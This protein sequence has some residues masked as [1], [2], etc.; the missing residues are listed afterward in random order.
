MKRARLGW[1]ALSVLLLLM[2]PAAR[3]GAQAARRVAVV[4]GANDA[5]PGRKP[6]RFSHQDAQAFARVLQDVAGFAA[7][8]VLVM[9]DPEPQALLEALD[10]KLA[11]LGASA[12]ETLVLFYYSGHADSAALFPHGRALALS[13]LR[14]RLGDARAGVRVGI[15]DACRGGGWTGA[16]GLSETAPFHVSLPEALSSEGTVLIASSSGIEDAHESE[17]LGGSFFTHHWNAG[18]R[19]AADRNADG[20][21][22]VGEAFEYAKALTIRDTA[23]HASV[24]QHPS[25]SMQLRGRHDLT[26]STI[27]AANALLSVTQH[28]GPL[29]LVHLESGVV[30][31]ELPKGARRMRLAVA[32]GRYLVRR[33][34]NGRVWGRELSVRAGQVEQVEEAGLE[35]MG[36]PVLAVKR[37]QPRPL[38]L[39]TLPAKSQ[40]ITFSLGVRHGE[41][42]PGV[43]L[44]GRA[45]TSEFHAPRGLTDRWQW[46]LPGLA[47]VYRG[48][49]HGAFEWLPWAG[50][51]AWGIGG[52]GLE[53]F[54]LEA[55][56]GGGID[57]R[58]WLGP[59]S[60][61]DFGLALLSGLRWNSNDVYTKTAD[62]TY[63]QRRNW[64]PP[65]TWAG[66][67]TLGYTHTIAD[68]VTLHVAAGYGEILLWSGELPEGGTHGKEHG[69]SLAFG[70]VQPIGLRP[71]PLLRIHLRDGFALNLD[72]AVSYSFA[73]RTVYE[74]YLAGVSFWW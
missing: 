71:T 51:P 26:L 30:V 39:S 17:Q 8:D 47:F 19:G 44:G 4:V 32:P 6:L 24:A 31:L 53:G 57:L 67:F 25:F 41:A 1:W 2:L 73:K 37:S 70:S 42:A 74:T 15:I 50:V 69:R 72:A 66:R 10:Q 28:L 60:S 18:L 3:A 36:S 65:S 62:G 40:E 46:A 16:K 12:G 33:R 23:I 54:V 5:A 29:E 68:T 21:V 45:F 58:R 43:R 48:G 13:D 63:K 55:S 11:I 22:T 27:T 61:L 14:A 35:L 59:R 9:F 34:Q 7:A 56:P 64:L 49:E 52:S 38:T 20:S